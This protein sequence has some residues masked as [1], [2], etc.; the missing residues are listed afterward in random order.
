MIS[1]HIYK[2]LHA[3]WLFFNINNNN[4]S[5]LTLSNQML[6]LRLFFKFSKY[7]IQLIYIEKFTV[8]CVKLCCDNMRAKKVRSFRICI[9]S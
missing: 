7:C 8:V 5:N 3:I 4:S 6:I 1:L 9:K 2:T